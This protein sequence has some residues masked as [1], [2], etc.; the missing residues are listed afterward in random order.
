[1]EIRGEVR[2]PG[3]YPVLEGERLA[4]A[5]RRAGGSRRMPTCVGP[6]L[7][8]VRVR[9]EQQRRLQEL[10]REEEISLLA[11]GAAESQAHT[12][13]GRGEGTAASRRVPP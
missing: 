8:R 3:F 9:E 7:T 1:M 10:I 5:L 2:F 6:S 4:P 13:F 11:Q 12:D